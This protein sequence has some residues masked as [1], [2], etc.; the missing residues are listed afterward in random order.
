M[1]EQNRPD[2]P[3]DVQGHYRLAADAGGG[4][5]EDVAGHLSPRSTEVHDLTTDDA[6]GRR[7]PAGGTSSAGGDEDEDDVAGHGLRPTDPK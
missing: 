6:E 7:F 5:E 3:D 4:D 1:T 2:A